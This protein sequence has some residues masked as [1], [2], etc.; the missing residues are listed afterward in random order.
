MMARFARPAAWLLLAAICFVT[1]AP[2]EMRPTT[3]EPADLERIFAFAVLGLI[4]ALGYPRRWVLVVCLV[5]G[6]AF[7]F[8]LAQ[9]FASTRHARL[10]DATVKALGGGGGVLAGMVVNR[11]ARR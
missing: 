3:S 1:L 9:I 10:E 4:F 7:A 6:A 5:A 8:E 2:I 11:I